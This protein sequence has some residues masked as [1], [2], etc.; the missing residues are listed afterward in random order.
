MGTESIFQEAPC[1]ECGAPA[2]LEHRQVRAWGGEIARRWLYRVHCSDFNC[3]P[4]PASPRLR[5][6]TAEPVSEKPPI[7]LGFQPPSR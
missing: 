2:V 7:P 1:P 4:G 5:A 6:V 3:T